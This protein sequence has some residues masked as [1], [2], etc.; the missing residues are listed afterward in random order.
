MS[1]AGWLG[2]RP[3]MPGLYLFLSKFD[4]LIDAFFYMYFFKNIFFIYI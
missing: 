3:T 4:L 1:Q 2:L